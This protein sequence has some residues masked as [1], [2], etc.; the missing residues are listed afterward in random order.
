KLAKVGRKVRKEIQ[1]NIPYS[2]FTVHNSRPTIHNPLSTPDFN[3]KLA[4]AG[5]QARKEIQ[6]TRHHSRFTIPHSRSTI[7]HPLS[8]INA[9]F[10]RKVRKEIQ[11]T[12][13]YS[14]FTTDHSRF[15]IPHFTIHYQRRILTQSS[16]R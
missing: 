13:R 3:A 1:I 4:K 11:I 10:Q 6:F 2:P 5:R 14:P 9:G 16:Q 15:T 7:H 12:I 8:T